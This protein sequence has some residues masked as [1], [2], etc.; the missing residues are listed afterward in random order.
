MMILK[1]LGMGAAVGSVSA[2]LSSRRNGKIN[3][4]EMFITSIVAISVFVILDIFAPKIGSASRLGVGVVV[5]A[6]LVDGIAVKKTIAEAGVVENFSGI[7]A[8]QAEGQIPNTIMEGSGIPSAF[9]TSSAMMS[10]APF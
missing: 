10:A 5:G 2:I 9:D 7:P 1:Y 4:K 3:L 6:D 8:G